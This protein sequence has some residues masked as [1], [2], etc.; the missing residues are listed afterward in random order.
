M[1][2]RIVALLLACL[3]VTMGAALAESPFT[4]LFAARL[5]ARRA[6]KD[7]YGLT[8]ALQ[9]Y[10]DE[11]QIASDDAGYTFYYY[12]QYEE[13]DYVLGRYT[14]RVEG[15]RAQASWSWDGQEV[16]NAGHGLASHAWGKDQLTEVWLI[17]H[18]TSDMSH[19]AF[20]A[21]NLA[22]S[23]GM[24][25]NGYATDMPEPVDEE[26]A[27]TETA[28]Q[29]PLMTSEEA[30]ELAIAI[31][32]QVYELTGEQADLARIY[33]DEINY[34]GS[35]WQVVNVVVWEDDRWQPGDGIYYVSVNLRDRKVDDILYIDGT[36]GNG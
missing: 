16:P 29:Q 24:P 14:V 19:Y 26:P 1:L 13:M 21:R 33:D 27:P 5:A 4:D 23:A 6:L 17:N 9:C 11:M 36:I 22:V 10:F 25:A 30:R 2:K 34:E 18:E 15:D 20:I 7:Q 8:S 35:V 28:P 32:Q 12:S 31:V 3:C